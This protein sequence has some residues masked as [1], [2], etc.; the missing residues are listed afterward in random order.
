MRSRLVSK[1]GESG[2]QEIYAFLA[3]QKQKQLSEDKVDSS[4][5]DAGAS[6]L[7]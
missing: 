7:R 6:A 3:D 5:P 2:F 4:D 1:L